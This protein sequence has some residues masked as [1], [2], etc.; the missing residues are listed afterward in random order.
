MQVKKSLCVLMQQQLVTFTAQGE[1]QS[2]VYRIESGLVL[3][4][5]QF[6]LWIHVAKTQFGDA[7]E[8]VVEDILQQGH[9]PMAQV[10]V[11]M[12]SCG[13]IGHTA[14]ISALL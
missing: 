5:S 4:R 7:G 2:G 3:L 14:V 1:K 8:L 11:A 12:G 6:P 9:S 13:I 10:G